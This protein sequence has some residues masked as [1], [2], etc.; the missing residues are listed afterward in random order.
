MLDAVRVASRATCAY[1][2]TMFHQRAESPLLLNGFEAAQRFFAGCLAEAGPEKEHLWVAHVDDQARCIH[3]AR[4]D[5]DDGGATLSLRDVIRDA[6]AHGSVGVILAH[7]H[8][9]GDA[10]PSTDDRQI[11]RR[12]ALAAE[13]VDLTL[14]DHLVMAGPDCRS[15]RAM[16]LL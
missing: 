11:T 4:H 9:G 13:A 10:T 12:L 16:G 1:A 7:N 8:P 2:E 6:A 5:G 14:L 3:L 15:M